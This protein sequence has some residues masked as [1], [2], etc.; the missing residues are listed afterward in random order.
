MPCSTRHFSFLRAVLRRESNSSSKKLPKC[1]QLPPTFG[2]PHPKPA[3]PPA[4]RTNQAPGQL[5]PRRP[6]RLSS[7]ISPFR[8]TPTMARPCGCPARRPPTSRA[9]NGTDYLRQV[10]P[11]RVRAQYPGLPHDLRRSTKTSQM[12]PA[13]CRARKMCRELVSSLAR[14][15]THMLVSYIGYLRLRLQPRRGTGPV[16]GGLARLGLAR[17]PSPKLPHQF[18]FGPQQP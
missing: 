9:S 14:P 6:T 11:E 17:H 10:V 15:N 1:I 3:R 13:L 4:R 7:P 2:R 8:E 16:L 5:K 12:A 18:H